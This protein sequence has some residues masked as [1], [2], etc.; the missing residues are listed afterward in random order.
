MVENMSFLGY[1][2][3]NI[4]YCNIK[5]I[6][7]KSYEDIT[8]YCIKIRI[9]MIEDLVRNITEYHN[10]LLMVPNTTPENLER[11]RQIYQDLQSINRRLIAAIIDLD[12]SSVTTLTPQEQTRVDDDEE[13]DR[14]IERVLPYLILSQQIEN[15][16]MDE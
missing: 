14:I 12:R 3:T 9:I 13:Q 8:I 6:N 10:K 1:V 11:Y 2:C 16:G 7:K 4:V 15:I 5:Q